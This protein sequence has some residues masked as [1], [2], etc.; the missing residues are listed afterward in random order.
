MSTISKIYRY[1]SMFCIIV[2]IVLSGFQF[3]PVMD[4]LR[5]NRDVVCIVAAALVHS[6]HDACLD[7]LHYYLYSTNFVLSVARLS[8]LVALES[9]DTRVANQI[10]EKDLDPQQLDIVTG[11]RVLLLQYLYSQRPVDLAAWRGGMSSSQILVDMGRRLSRVGSD[12]AVSELAYLLDDGWRDPWQRG[13]NARSVGRAYLERGQLDQARVA[14]ERAVSS[15]AE[16]DNPLAR[17]Y[18]CYAYSRLGTIAEQQG[19]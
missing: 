2:M 12:A 5:W 16:A 18:A 1:L 19:D 8:S 14:Y 17:E 3:L 11:S 4:R 9:G 13:L 7:D 6:P 15:F 10:L